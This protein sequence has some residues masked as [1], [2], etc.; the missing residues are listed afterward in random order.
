MGLAMVVGACGADPGG[1]E[2]DSSDVV[3]PAECPAPPAFK[4]KP[5]KYD[6]PEGQDYWGTRDG[7]TT[8]VNGTAQSPIDIEGPR[9]GASRA[10]GIGAHAYED[11]PGRFFNNGHTMMFLFPND[12]KGGTLEVDGVTYTLDQ[13]HFHAPSEHRI[14]G[15]AFPMEA[16]F[17]HTAPPLMPGGPPRRVVVA[18][19][20][21]VGDAPNPL[22]SH[23]FPRLESNEGDGSC[24]RAEGLA[25]TLFARQDGFYRY[26]GSLTTPDCSEDVHWIVMQ[27][28]ISVSAE[29]IGRF[30]AIFPDNARHVQPEGG[31]TVTFYPG[32]S[33]P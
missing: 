11:A 17:V 25:E 31:R 32:E 6:G 13:F 15:Q 4:G 10:T 27:T 8:C 26:D 18:V 33:E 7:F 16:H 2:A 28:P 20:L 29:E 9:N 5:W 12:K 19:M 21:D 23:I 14:E 22:I 3:D 30:D 24:M 1:M